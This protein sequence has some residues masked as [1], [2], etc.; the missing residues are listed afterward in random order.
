MSKKG[1]T[2][3]ELLV[4]IAIIAL[5]AAIALPAIQKARNQAVIGKAKAE[6]ISLGSTGTTIYLDLKSRGYV[7]LC[8]YDLTDDDIPDFTVNPPK[9]DTTTTGYATTNFTTS[10]FTDL[11]DFKH[12]WDGPYATYQPATTFST[13]NGTYPKKSDGAD[14]PPTD[15]N[16]THWSQDKFPY[17]TP[18]DPWGHPYGMGWNDTEKVMVIYSAGPDEKIETNCGDTTPIG[19]DLLYKFR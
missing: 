2:L 11:D 14:L 4:V 7:R 13:S 12:H 17:G 8:D 5:L 10:D 19:D 18:L 15:P 3:I 16:P 1:F 6:M 9:I